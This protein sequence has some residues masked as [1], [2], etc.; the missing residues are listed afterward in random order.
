MGLEIVEADGI[1]NFRIYSFFVKDLGCFL[2][3]GCQIRLTFG[4]KI[5]KKPG[6]APLIF[7][8]AKPHPFRSRTI[9]AFTGI[10]GVGMAYF[11]CIGFGSYIGL[12]VN[13][14][15]TLLPFVL[16]GIG[17]DDMYVLILTME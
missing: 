11:E 10:I 14:M 4:I 2:S 6:Q 1:N 7:I 16:M 17:V 8:F 12:K 5:M 15:I 13:G 3:M 9:V